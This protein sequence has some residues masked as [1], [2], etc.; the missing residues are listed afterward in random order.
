MA[1]GLVIAGPVWAE[2]VS[3]TI[4]AVAPVGAPEVSWSAVPMDLPPDADV[5]EAMIMTPDAIAGPW[6]VDLTPGPWLISGFTAVD[7]YEVQATVT[8]ET[9]VIDVPVL[10]VED[11]IALRCSESATCA[12]CDPETGLA[13]TLPKGWA[14]ERP[15]RADLGGGTLADAVSTV[16]FEDIEGDGAAVWFL[17][18]VD[19][20]ADDSSPC[21]DVTLGVMCTFDASP[22]AE[23]AFAVIA[24]SLRLA[25]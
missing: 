18:P 5:L 6:V 2:T 10:V 12:Y 22:A 15:Y 11:A 1:L 13:A 23:A 14:L 19:W 3:V 20:V 4:R 17:N 24:P 8:P 9:T 25:E 21:R 7:L 16:F